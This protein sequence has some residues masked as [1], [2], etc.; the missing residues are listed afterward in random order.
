MEEFKEARIKS[1]VQSILKRMITFSDYLEENLKETNKDNI[2]SGNI[3]TIFDNL[4]IEIN[5]IQIQIENELSPIK[6][7]KY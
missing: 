3:Q 6:K 5:N 2:N 4:N 1:K 7:A